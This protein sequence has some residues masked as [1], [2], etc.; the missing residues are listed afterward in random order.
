MD[1][2]F[3]ED[4]DNEEEEEV[5][6][7][8]IDNIYQWSKQC[9]DSERYNKSLGR[10]IVP[11]YLKEREFNIMLEGRRIYSYLR[12]S[13]CPRPQSKQSNEP[14][15]EQMQIDIVKIGVIG[16][17]S[18]LENDE[19]IST[20]KKSGDFG[21][22]TKFVLELMKIGKSIGRGV[23]LECAHTEA[24]QTFGNSLENKLN[25][26]KYGEDY[27]HNWVCS[28]QNVKQY[29]SNHDNST[30]ESKKDDTTFKCVICNR[31]STGYGNN[32]YPVSLSG[33]CC[34]NCNRLVVMD[35][36]CNSLS[37]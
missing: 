16:R 12:W 1:F 24:G 37:K 10:K 35:R 23:Y 19:K 18:S 21:H 28:L 3:A 32:P 7:E 30:D 15:D 29:L 14:K 2:L 17:G 26:G 31:K 8:E 36:I 11:F 33:L 4:E 20:R 9:K 13:A 22:G 34:D 6:C 27:D 5:E 25:F